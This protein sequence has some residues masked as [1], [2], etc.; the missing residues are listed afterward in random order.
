MVHIFKSCMF[1]MNRE[2]VVEIN[3]ASTTVYNGHLKSLRLSDLGA[4]LVIN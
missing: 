3:L 2:D 1:L 4:Y